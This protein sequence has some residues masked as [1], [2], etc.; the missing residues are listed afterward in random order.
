VTA[1]ERYARM[2]KSVS[3]L[4]MVLAAT[5]AL[6]A[7]V[8][9]LKATLW[10]STAAKMGTVYVASAIPSFLHAVVVNLMN[11]VYEMLAVYLNDMENHRCVVPSCHEA[12]AVRLSPPSLP[13]QDGH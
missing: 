2:A 11:T 5:V 3:V 4:A 13:P 1:N 7:A 6:I 9:A 10:A 12:Y 8:F